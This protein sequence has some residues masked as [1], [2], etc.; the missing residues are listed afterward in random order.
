MR[1]EKKDI[2]CEK[3]KRVEKG[4]VGQILERQRKRD[5]EV[6]KVEKKVNVRKRS[7]REESKIRVRSEKKNKEE[8]KC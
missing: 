7:W 4:E 6:K 1:G 3:R 2:R 8:G 5:G